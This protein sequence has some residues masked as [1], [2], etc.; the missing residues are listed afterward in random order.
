[1][2]F[3]ETV[4][5]SV[6]F[7]LSPNSHL[8]TCSKQ[9]NATMFHICSLDKSCIFLPSSN[10]SEGKPCISGKLRLSL[11]QAMTVRGISVQVRGLAKLPYDQGTF[12]QSYHE[13][14]T[15]VTTQPLASSH[16][17]N[18]F[19]LP[20]G[21]YEFPFSIPLNDNM[22]ETVSCRRSSYRL[23]QVHAI[24]QR[25]WNRNVTVSKP[26]RIYKRFS[27]EESLNWMLA[28]NSIDKQWDNVA[29]YNVSIPDVNIPFGATFPVKLRV[30]P[31]SKRIKLQALT[32]D[33]VEQH[34]V[35]MK[36][37]ATYSA[38]FN[39]HFLSSNKEHVI[40]RERHNLDDCTVS[41][42]EDSD[43]EWCI[44]KAISLP[45]DL[46]EYTQDVSS[47]AIRIKHH[48]AFTV[49]LLGVGE[50]V[51]MIKGTIPLN[52]YMSPHA[53]SEDGTVRR[54]HIDRFHDEY[55]PPPPLYSEHQNDLLLPIAEAL[56]DIKKL[57]LNCEQQ[58]DNA[59][60]NST[61]RDCAPSYE[62]AIQTS[63]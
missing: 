34:E 31:L 19:N 4:C 58:L 6:R 49:E 9:A 61:R 12:F 1:M 27:I 22:L 51:S 37:P 39:V 57:R 30:A 60:F 56:L 14:N 46:E 10:C 59:S 50:G 55:V 29:Q 26:I 11:A 41:G 62:T 47:N 52:I 32:I 38:Q 8:D 54:L 44:T 35:K 40:F 42:S 5:C 45:Q 48:V 20:T 15:F 23:Y 63:H 7:D 24:I 17:Q 28:L 25:R 2:L 3:N 36:A 16:K 43:L 21:D 13:E 33:V 53:I 18:P